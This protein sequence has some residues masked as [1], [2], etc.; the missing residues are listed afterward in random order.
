MALAG[1]A[2]S[3][4]T[5]PALKRSLP[6]PPAFAKRVRVSTPKVGED[7]ELVAAR[8]RAGRAKANDTIAC[9]TDWYA[10]VRAT[11]G[12]DVAD[13]YGGE[14]KTDCDKTKGRK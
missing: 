13:Q 6:P 10:M 14:A 12:Q 9:F 5:R 11:Y 2:A 7:V 1:C 4:P 3:A 8:E